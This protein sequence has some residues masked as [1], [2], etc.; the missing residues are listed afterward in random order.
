MRMESRVLW[1]HR[2]YRIHRRPLD[3]Y[4]FLC[5]VERDK[6]KNLSCDKIQPFCYGAQLRKRTYSCGSAVAH[7]SRNR[8]D[9]NNTKNICSINRISFE[10]IVKKSIWLLHRRY[11]F[12]GLFTKFNFNYSNVINNYTFVIIVLHL[13]KISLRWGSHINRLFH[14]INII[15]EYI[16]VVLQ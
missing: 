2:V 12:S 1:S 9:W 6:N 4:Y 14:Q 13:Y 15:T 8:Y 5:R 11:F 10:I 16:G 3:S 7:N